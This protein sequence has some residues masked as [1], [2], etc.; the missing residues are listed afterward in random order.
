MSEIENGSIP[1]INHTEEFGTFIRGKFMILLSPIP[2]LFGVV[3]FMS[4]G[5]QHLISGRIF[6]KY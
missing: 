1:R 3:P 5:R 4:M 2:S 6:L